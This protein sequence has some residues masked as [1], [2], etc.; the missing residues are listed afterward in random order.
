[1]VWTALGVLGIACLV[2]AAY[3]FAGAAAGMAM[4]GV[5]LL[6]AAVDGRRS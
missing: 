1:M 6:L 4:L 3:L 5:W 2:A